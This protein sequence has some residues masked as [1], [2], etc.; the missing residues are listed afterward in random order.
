[1]A[2][3][4]QADLRVVPEESFGAALQYFT[5]SKEHNVE[6]RGRAKQRGLK[7]NEYGVF[8]ADS[9]VYVAGRTE[10]D[11]YGALELPL[12]PAELREARQEFEW[13]ETGQLPQLIELSDIQG[14]LHMHTTA[15]DGK[16]TIAEMAAAAR[17]RGLKYIAITDHS[18]RVSM[19]RG[20]DPTRLLAQWDE[21]DQ[22]NRQAN[23]NFVILKGIECDILEQG[24]MDLPDEIL[25][26]ADWVL[27]S[28]H[29]GQRQSQDQITQRIVGAI[30]NPH[31]TAIA[32]PT[33]RLLNRRDAYDVDLDAILQAAKQ[34]GKLLELNANPERLDLNDLHCAAAKRLGIPI[35]INTDAH[36]ILG[37]DVMRFGVQ[38]A[39][40]G[41][42]T[43]QD[44][45]NTRPWPQLRKMLG[46]K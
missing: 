42:L 19:A 4:L 14:D 36:S 29:Y 2:S 6:V 30:R 7:I 18:Q 31:V 20:L 43:R 23:D 13:A 21:I 3:G 8:R 39:R 37:L 12:I 22:L 34:H 41:G 45:V 46:R 26:Q 35:V 25:A 10:A 38:Q 33:G 32:H 16:A 44:V 24:G 1:M 11:V 17:Q 28:L 5:G 40:R 9:D 27:A 15:T